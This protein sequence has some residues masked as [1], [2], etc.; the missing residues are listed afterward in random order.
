MKKAR[1][2]DWYVALSVAVTTIL[3]A[4]VG[5]QFHV[6]VETILWFIFGAVVS[7]GLAALR[8]QA[9][10]LGRIIELLQEISN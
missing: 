9:F 2:Y 1:N 7:I 6:S 10:A 5:Q 4:A 3:I 8:G